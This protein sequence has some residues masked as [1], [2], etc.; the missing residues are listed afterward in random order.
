MLARMVLMPDHRD[1][2]IPQIQAAFYDVF[3]QAVLFHGFTDYMRDYDV[4]VYAAADPR[5]GSGRSTCDTGSPA[6]SGQQ[7]HPSCRPPPGAGR[8][9][10]GLPIAVT[11]GAWR[12]TC[13]ASGGRS[14][15][16]G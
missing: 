7:R 11:A 8:W 6:A 9:I 1:M 5:A 2:D 16:R 4:F 13:G 3:D 14:C 10:T 12:A 15:I